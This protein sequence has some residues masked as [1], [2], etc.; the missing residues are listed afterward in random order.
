MT[1]L[2]ILHETEIIKIM[3][4]THHNIRVN[5]NGETIVSHSECPEHS[6][7]FVLIRLV[8]SS[9]LKLPQQKLIVWLIWQNNKI[10][11]KNLAFFSAGD[12]S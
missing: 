11:L 2:H 5:V 4:L 10:N 1:S 8:V 9:G 6:A 3:L 12:V 7:P